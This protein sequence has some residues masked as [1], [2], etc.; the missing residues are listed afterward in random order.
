MAW[1]ELEKELEN[2]RAKVDWA[3]GVHNGLEGMMDAGVLE[4]EVDG[5]FTAVADP[6]RRE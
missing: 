1:P 6:V 5:S 2:A 3:Q 4:Q